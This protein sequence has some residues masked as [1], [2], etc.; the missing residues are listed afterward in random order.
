MH[1]KFVPDVLIVLL[2]CCLLTGSAHILSLS[3]CHHIIGKVID[4]PPNLTE[5]LLVSL[6]PLAASRPRWVQCS[7]VYATS[8]HC[9]AY[10]VGEN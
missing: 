7:Y 1:I 2:T 4:P 5:G 9:W 6:A 8:R 3:I 10:R